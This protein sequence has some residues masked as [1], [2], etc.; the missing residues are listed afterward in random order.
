MLT[1]LFEIR[2]NAHTPR[3]LVSCDEGTGEA[4]N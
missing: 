1:T 4:V 2:T 3:H